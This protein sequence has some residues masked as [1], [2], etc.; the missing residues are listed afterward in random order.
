MR[1][2]ANEGGIVAISTGATA[3]N[4]TEKR[5]NG[6]LEHIPF[7]FR[8]TL[9]DADGA[10]ALVKYAI[11]KKGLKRFALIKS[12][13]NEYSIGLAVFFEKAVKDNGGQIVIEQ[14]INDGDV[15]FSAQVTS[16]KKAN[17]DAV[18]FTGYYQEASSILLAMQ[19]QGLN[20][21][22]IGGDGLQ[23]P[24]L[25]NIAKDASI[26]TMFYASFVAD[27]DNS[28]VKEFKE[29]VQARGK[30]ADTFS[31]NGYD[32]AYLLVKAIEAAKV[33]DCSDKAQR[34]LI[35]VELNKITDFDGV[36]GKMSID[37]TGSTVKEPFLQEVVK[38]SD[39]S[40]G[41]KSLN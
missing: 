19:A 9:Q 4:V 15:D 7:A 28:K 30:D 11:N 8:N 34:D 3:S 23:S 26:G 36:T 32:A 40:Y 33:T 39:G 1:D 5:V 2:I 25:W 31:A 22:L 29:K 10:P 37:D 17:V 13:N 27:S 6:K 24:D 41:T 18:I 21:P 35:R 20:I 12:Q 14:A 16:I 38:N